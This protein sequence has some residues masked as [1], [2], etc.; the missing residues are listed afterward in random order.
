VVGYAEAMAGAWTPRSE[1][2]IQSAIDAGLVRE[3]HVFDAK[4]EQPPPIGKNLDIAIDIASFAVDSGRILYGLFDPKSPTAPMVRAPFDISGLPERLDQVAGGG[5]IDPPLRITCEPIGSDEQ[6]GLGYL[7]VVIPMSSDAPH[8]VDGKYRGRGDTTN[9]VLS[10]AEVRRH[11]EERGRRAVDLA[12]LPDAEVARDP[13]SAALR[14]QGH[15]FV[16]A[17]PLVPRADLLGRILTTAADWQAWLGSTLPRRLLEARQEDTAPYLFGGTSVSPRP[18][19]WAIHAYEIGVDRHLRPNGASPVREDN[20]LDL[21]I[22][23]DGGLRLFCGR[24]STVLPRDPPVAFVFHK[25]IATLTYHVVNAAI[26]VADQADYLGGWGFAVAIR[27]IGKAIVDDSAYGG[28][29]R[30]VDDYAQPV[31][32]SLAELQGDPKGV[33]TRLLGRLYRGMG[34]QDFI[35]ASDLIPRGFLA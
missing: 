33:V 7:L 17:Q 24:A 34:V 35:L 19:G 22:R 20:L 4:R 11:H 16:V 32:V 30:V 27:G 13:T 5:L 6:P 15:L 31:S 21:E 1:A 12:Q 10:D 25:L 18:D 3:T 2:D 9:I 23:D 29:M 28:I 8:Q 26:T 14:T